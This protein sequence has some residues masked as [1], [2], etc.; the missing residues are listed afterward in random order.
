MSKS[1]RALVVASVAVAATAGGWYYASPYLMESRLRDAAR[2]GDVA[3]VSKAV[4][5]TSLQ[6][7]ISVEMSSAAA[8]AVGREHPLGGAIMARIASAISGPLVEH[9]VSPELVTTMLRGELPA[10]VSG[11]TAHGRM[12][13][14]RAGY[15]DINHFRTHFFSGNGAE[16]FSLIFERRGVNQWMLVGLNLPRGN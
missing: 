5:F 16:I 2:R 8:E 3:A 10:L 11:G 4:D 13:N 14:I 6:R 15:D 12:D 1:S 9:V 7:S